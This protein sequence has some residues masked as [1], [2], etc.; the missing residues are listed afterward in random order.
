MPNGIIAK[1]QIVNFRFPT[2]ATARTITVGLEYD[3]PPGEAFAVLK[4]AAVETH[5]V[6][7]KPEPHVFLIDFADSAI[8]YE[9]K[10]W[11]TEASAH[12]KIENHVRTNIWYR[13]KEKGFNIPFPM[14]TIEH[15]RMEKKQ[16]LQSQAASQNRLEVLKDLW[17]FAPLTAEQKNELAAGASDVF[18]ADGQTLFHQDDPG[19]SLYVIR[20]GEVDVLVRVGDGTPAKVATLKA[21]NFFGEM[22]ALTGQPRS[23]TIRAAG[24]LSCVRIG[25]EDL[26]TV[27]AA[28]PA[29]MEK[30]SQI[31][32]ERNAHRHAKVKE[33]D[34]A[35]ANQPTVQEEQKSL[36]G[37]MLRFFG[38]GA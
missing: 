15:V 12:L 14:R 8:V 30:I 4:A 5:G 2:M 3:L 36:L 7:H 25:K 21:G 35:A 29:I 1:E 18:L 38:R 16:Q 6:S 22:S 23:A 9:V 11:I 19:D 26:Q 31:I 32:A 13:L 33:A 28:D 27:F 17:M 34:T 24:E 20:K 10:F 37:K